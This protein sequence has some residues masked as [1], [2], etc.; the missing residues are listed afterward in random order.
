MSHSIQW[1]LFPGNLSHLYWLY[2]VLPHSVEIFQ[3][4]GDFSA[5][6]LSVSDCNLC[7]IKSSLKLFCN[8]PGLPPYPFLSNKELFFSSWGQQA[9]A[10]WH[11]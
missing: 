5:A 10:T 9:T 8:H 7:S 6:S 11:C 3:R 1:R 4:G 2:G